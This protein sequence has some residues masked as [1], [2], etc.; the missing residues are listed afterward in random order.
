MLTVSWAGECV[1]LL[2]VRLEACG[3]GTGEP[4]CKGGG[5][6]LGHCRVWVVQESPA[7]SFGSTTSTRV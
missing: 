5:G 4:D 7:G 1:A 2:E 3:K 6:R